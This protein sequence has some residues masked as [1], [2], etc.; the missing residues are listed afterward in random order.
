MPDS[1]LAILVVT[2]C[3]GVVPLMFV[4][5]YR[6][7]LGITRRST[8]ADVL[9]REDGYKAVFMRAADN[10]EDIEYH[11][12]K[13][14]IEFETDDGKIRVLSYYKYDA[15]DHQKVFPNGQTEVLYSASDPKKSYVLKKEFNRRYLAKALV[16]L[17]FAVLAA[18]VEVSVFIY[19]GMI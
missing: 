4:L 2:A 5:F 12:L 13:A 11:P 10:A 7:F 14:V 3:V 15:Q 16:V 19:L 8:T 6:C 1:L 18:G 9:S 17:V